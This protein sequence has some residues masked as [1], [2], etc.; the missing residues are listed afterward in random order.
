M[1]RF[2]ISICLVALAGWMISAR[3]ARAASTN[4]MPD[5][6][7]VYEML[8]ANLPGTTE[9]EL[10]RAAIMGLF[11]Q[12]RGKVSMV[13]DKGGTESSP[14]GHLSRVTAIEDEVAY[15]R[16][17]RV[18]AELASGLSEALERL[19][20]TNQLKGL[21]LDLRFSAGDDFA[22]AVAAADLFVAK[23][24]P[25][26]DWGDG[27][28]KSKEKS[29]AVRLPVAVLV[30]RETVGAAEALAAMVR[31]AGIGLILGRT[32]AGGAMVAREFSLK[33]GQRL[34]IASTPV[35]LGDGSTIPSQ[36][37]QPDIEVAVS[38]PDER[39]YFENAYAI[40]PSTNVVLS[41]GL[42]AATEGTNRPVRRP[43]ISEA[44]LVRERREGTNFNVEDFTLARER[45]PEKPL[46]RDPALARAVD[47]LKG[48]A[49]V[50][51]P[52]S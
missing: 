22:A 52:H 39:A 8:R 28:V 43:R 41:A 30:N 36:G 29:N 40:L 21:V 11:E 15:L 23:E 14:I 44:D 10:N 48:L 20:A 4:D 45:E 49:L 33:N 35:K 26:L 25:L 7:E 6:T 2:A 51:R 24:R 19:S 16:V 17:K 18:G 37:L 46:I 42:T 27:M 3:S 38:P 32:T 50:R 12:L 1:T 31:E 34:R 5:F 13:G 47:L 9:A